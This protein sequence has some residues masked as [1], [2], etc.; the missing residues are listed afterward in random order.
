MN[1]SQVDLTDVAKITITTEGAT[2]IG[3]DDI[4]F[5]K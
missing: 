1:N 4:E 3:I 5:G 2:E